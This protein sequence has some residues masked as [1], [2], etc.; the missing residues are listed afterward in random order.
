MKIKQ[1]QK[2]F[3]QIPI[4]IAVG[5]GLLAFGTVGYFGV[6][7]YQ[8]NNIKSEKSPEIIVEDNKTIDNLIAN[9]KGNKPTKGEPAQLISTLEENAK[10]ITEK[11]TEPQKQLTGAGQVIKEFLDDPS[12]DNFRVFCNKAKNVKSSQTEETLSEDR[13][14]ME[15]VNKTLFEIVSSCRYLN[16]PNSGVFFVSNPESLLVNLDS[17]DTDNIRTKK[18][19][20]NNQI[21]ELDHQY[22]IYSYNPC[23]I[24]SLNDFFQYVFQSAEKDS[25]R[26][27][28]TLIKSI[29]MPEVEIRNVLENEKQ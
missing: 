17:T 24:A 9:T 21:K 20:Y 27:I 13:T 4:I 5:I 6:K 28:G 23:G 22:K 8:K 3:I 25:F 29:K 19:N 11:I 7:Q 16:D 14:K 10:P 15:L 1:I 2:G 12:L 26:C 18:I